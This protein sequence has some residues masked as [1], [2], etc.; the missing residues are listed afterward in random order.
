[1]K[2]LKDKLRAID[3]ILFGA[4]SV[5]SI[6]S[7]LVIYGARDSEF[8]S[9]RMLIMQVAMTFMGLVFMVI[10]ANLDLSDLSPIFYV[11]IY[12]LSAI[13]LVLLL[14]VGENAGTN[15]NWI[16]IPIIGIS[17]QPSEFVRATFILTF[18]KH[19]SVVKDEINRS[20]NI[21][22]LLLHAGVIL[23]LLLMSGDLGMTLVYVGIMAVMLYCAGLSLW[24]FLVAIVGVVAAFPF[25]WQFLAEYQRRRILI[26]FNP[27][28]DPTDVGLQQIQSRT[29][30]AG[31]GFFGRGING[32]GSY[33][34]MYGS[35]TDFFFS[36]YS[37]M[38]GFFG[39]IVLLGLMVVIVVR[40]IILAKRSQ[41]LYGS[42]VCAGVAGMVVVQT[43]ENIGMCLCL[44]PV[45]GI[46][47]P[48]L[49]AGGSSVLSIYILF[50]LVHS[51]VRKKIGTI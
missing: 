17:V 2:F 18:A 24:C 29:A 23:G 34:N 48:F 27:D 13:F 45:V 3:P 4:T 9:L 11:I 7:L 50:G 20:K 32:A 36:T 42:F 30:I 47:L 43:V 46:T 31:G 51:T 35:L 22:F 5:L 26:G 40:L 19:L 33:K 15:Q 28:L 21:I 38:F 44:L 37:E 8:G 25:L 41:T 16:K 49:S 39:C 12:G 6:M 10:I 14:F 1:M